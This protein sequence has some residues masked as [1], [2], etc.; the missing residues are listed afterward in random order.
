MIREALV[1][2]V[3]QSTNLKVYKDAGMGFRYVLRSATNP[4]KVL[5]T[6]DITP[7]DY[8]SM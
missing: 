8:E 4:K 5:F 3:R 7:K 2:E 1:K 6:T